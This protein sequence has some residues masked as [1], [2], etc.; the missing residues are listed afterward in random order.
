MQGFHRNCLLAA[1]RALEAD[2]SPMSV[3]IRSRPIVLVYITTRI[4]DNKDSNE[5]SMIQLLP[6]NNTAM[7]YGYT[8]FNTILAGSAK[9]TCVSQ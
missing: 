6:V 8:W 7:K 1:H 9:Y 3:R 2:N 5:Q 4:L